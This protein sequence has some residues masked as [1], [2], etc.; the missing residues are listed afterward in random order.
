MADHP[1]AHGRRALSRRLR[2]LSAVC[3]QF[4]LYVGFWFV[5]V[6]D[7]ALSEIYAGLIVAGLSTIASD[8]VL[9]DKIALFYANPGWLSLAGRLPREILV[10]SARVCGVLYRRLST[11]ALPRSGIF[12]L[13]FDGDGDDAASATR[14]A[15]AITY[16]SVS[17]NSIVVGIDRDRGLLFY[18]QLEPAPVSPLLEHLGGKAS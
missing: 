10:D 11:G 16:G 15:L 2:R 6:G 1:R 12:T 5:F 14:R 13:S 18:H 7:F 3:L 9:A 8:I 4:A 17:P